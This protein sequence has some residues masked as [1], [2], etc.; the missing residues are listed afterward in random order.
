MAILGFDDLA[1]MLF[2]FVLGGLEKLHIDDVVPPLRLP[3]PY[4]I[5]ARIIEVGTKTRMR[6]RSGLPLAKNQNRGG[7]QIP[8]DCQ[9]FFGL[10][11]W[12]PKFRQN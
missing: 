2:D 5:R 8:F 1:L 9:P 3:P 6:A 10:R 4:G 7:D 12:L 11:K